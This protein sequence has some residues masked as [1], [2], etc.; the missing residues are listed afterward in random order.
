MVNLL[1]ITWTRIRTNM[2]DPRIRKNVIYFMGGKMLGF[3][4]VLTAMWVFLP[5]V[6]HAASHGTVDLP[7]IKP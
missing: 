1:R 5:S 2:R 4:L 3:A 6:V 7:T